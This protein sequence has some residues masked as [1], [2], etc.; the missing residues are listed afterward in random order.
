MKG[1]SSRGPS[2]GVLDEMIAKGAS[3][4][5]P[6]IDV[7]RQIRR[8]LDMGYLEVSIV[9]EVEIGEKKRTV[10][11][12]LVRAEP[13]NFKNNSFLGDIQGSNPTEIE[14]VINRFS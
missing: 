7:K 1:G 10:I 6:E 14:N 11:I 12:P 3:D 9:V 2:K 8:F 4:R 5:D 13:C